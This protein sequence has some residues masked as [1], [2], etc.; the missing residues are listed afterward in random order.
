M[1]GTRLSFRD[2]SVA[3]GGID[4][5]HRIDLDVAEGEWVGLIGP[6][7]AGKSTVLEAAAGIVRHR[8]SIEIGGEE[9]S[10]LAPDARARRVA[11]VPQRPVMPSG[12]KVIDY[13]MLGRSP[14]SG[15]FGVESVDD[16]V[17]ANQALQSLDLVDLGRRRVD[18]LSG[19]EQQRVVIARALAQSSP[20]LLLDEPTSAL[21]VG[22]RME[23]LDH[24]DEA[25]RSRALTVISA[26]H[27]LTLAAQF[28]DRLVM[29][30]QGRVVADGPAAGVL[31]VDRIGHHYGARV[32]V[33]EDDDGGVIVIPTRSPSGDR[34][35]AQAGT[36]GSIDP[37]PF[38]G[39][40]APHS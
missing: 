14:Y 24:I 1:S 19:G 30:A 7:G 4:R 20:V 21:D 9:L 17:S 27:D 5:V 28:C 36:D 34:N 13:V 37:Q 35:S 38:F 32:K 2:V 26:I 6:N 16:V 8:G 3:R 18:E 31:T 11:F 23:V 12:V 25:R 10:G 29:L 40:G 39:S 15:R 33:I 22:I